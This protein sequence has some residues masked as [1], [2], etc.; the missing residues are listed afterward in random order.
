MASEGKRF[1]NTDSSDYWCEVSGQGDPILLL[2]GFTGN[3]ATWSKL[4]SLLERNHQVITID[5]PGHGKTRV[6]SPKTMMDC[7]QDIKLIIEQLGYE[8]VNLLGYSMGGRTALSFAVTYPELVRSLVLESAS[9]GLEQEEDR[10]ARIKNDQKLAERI[11]TGGLE[12]FVDFWGSLPLFES[13]KKLPDLIQQ[14][15]REERLSQ[16]EEGLVMSLTYMGNGVQPS[17]WDNLNSLTIPV[18][19]LV[20]EWDLKFINLNEAM[21]NRLPIS[22]LVIVEKAGHAIHVEQSDFFG[23]I[24]SEFILDKN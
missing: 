13:Q 17:W 10:I 14:S 18:L 12:S 2:H 4:V 24:V 7:C 5:L 11:R 21:Q 1:I 16:H 6:D 9:P 15:I 3:T 23:K 22:N 19:L 20:G 8:K